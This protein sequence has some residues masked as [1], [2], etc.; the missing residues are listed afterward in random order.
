MFKLDVVGLDPS[1]GDGGRAQGM[2]ERATVTSAAPASVSDRSSGSSKF[3]LGAGAFNDSI[4]MSDLADDRNEKFSQG[5]SGSGRISDSYQMPQQQQQQEKRQQ[6][7]GGNQQTTDDDPCKFTFEKVYQRSYLGVNQSFIIAKK[8]GFSS[9]EVA[10]RIRGGSGGHSEWHNE[11]QV[12]LQPNF[13]HPNIL[14]YLGADQSQSSSSGRKKASR[15]VRDELPRISDIRKRNYLLDS[16]EEQKAKEVREKEM[17][18]LAGG[19]VKLRLQYWLLNRFDNCIVLR[20][21]LREQALT[22]PQMILIARGIIDGLHYLHENGEFHGIDKGQAVRGFIKSTRGALRRVAFV[23]K[24]YK[25]NMWPEYTCSIIHRN[26]SSM[27]IV[28]R[29]PHLTPSIWNFGHSKIH[30]PFQPTNHVNLIDQRLKDVFMSSPY[31]PPEVLQE[32]A[33]LTLKAWKSIDMYAC[34]VLFWELLSRCQLPPLANT[35]EHDNQERVDPEPYQEPFQREFGPNPST[36]MLHYAVCRL[37][38]R[39]KLKDSWLLGRKSY[40]FTHTIQDLW[41][42]DFDARVHTSTVMD[43]LSRLD[44]VD[45]DF[46]HDFTPRNSKSFDLDNQW[47]PRV[48]SVQVPPF[49]GKCEPNLV[50]LD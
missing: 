38:C 30:Y 50:F 3:D 7:T 6:A 19:G 20:D 14:E 40:M 41:D 31:S 39:P 43:R 2:Q 13:R 48:E 18:S 44:T 46:R 33:Y 9:E 27:N 28:L 32:R 25:I 34:G 37:H 36:A 17:L 16:Y 35:P 29:G 26:L 8:K 22:W 4:K 24:T 23:D 11:L 1:G 10:I 5:S 45:E 21:Y 12:Y 15:F 42:Q 49:L 47:P